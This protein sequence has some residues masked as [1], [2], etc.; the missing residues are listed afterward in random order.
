MWGISDL[1]FRKEKM[2]EWELI[3]I[4]CTVGAAIFGAVWL[5]MNDCKRGINARVKRCENAIDAVARETG[6]HH[7]SFITTDAF[8]RFENNLNTRFDS[9]SDNINHLTTRIDDFIIASRNG[10]KA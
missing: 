10:K 1:V 6:N 4:I 2:N 5:L 3:G 8:D 7:R 9:M